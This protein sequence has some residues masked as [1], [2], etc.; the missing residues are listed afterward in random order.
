MLKTNPTI[1]DSTVAL[2][3][4]PPSIP[5]RVV[6]VHPLPEYRLALRF[7]DGLRGEVHMRELVFSEHA[8]VFAWVRDLKDFENVSCEDGHVQWA[9][10]LDIAPDASHDDI[11]KYG[12]QILR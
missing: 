7:Q 4:A 11:Q 5:W 8:G 6:E 10:G 9:C 12:V 2:A 3:S 1:E